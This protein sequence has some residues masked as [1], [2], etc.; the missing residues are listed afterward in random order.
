AR[1]AAAVGGTCPVSGSPRARRARPGP[2][3]AGA[4]KAIQEP[5][6]P[7]ARDAASVGVASRGST[8]PAGFAGLQNE[9]ERDPLAG[10]PCPN[11][12]RAGQVT[13]RRRWIQP[14][15]EARPGRARISMARRSS[16]TAAERT[17]AARG[18][19]EVLHGPSRTRWRP[20]PPV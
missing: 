8:A 14:A 3:R 7:G 4:A 20:I 10:P 19:G 17:L 13:T 18:K 9:G 1:V 2:G 16:V 5:G 12:A 11:D 15:R 6:G